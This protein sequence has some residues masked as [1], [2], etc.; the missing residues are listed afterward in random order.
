MNGQGTISFDEIRVDTNYV[1]KEGDKKADDVLK[2][3]EFDREQK[4][5]I[6]PTDDT[7]V[8]ES[9]IYLGQAEVLENESN[10]DRRDRLADLLYQNPGL[11]AQFHQRQLNS[12]TLETGLGD[13]SE[14]EDEDFY[15]PASELL[16]DC[17]QFLIRDSLRRAQERL[18]DERCRADSQDVHAIIVQRRNLN[19][20]LSKYELWGSQVV[21]SRPVSG[22][23]LSPDQKFVACGSWHG[24]AK[25][26]DSE[27]L[28]I[29]TS[30]DAIH[31]DKIGGLDW[32][33]DSTLLAT[34]G[35]DKLV[36]VWKP[37]SPKDS[38]VELKGH[39]GRVVKVKFHPSDRYVASASFDMTWRLWDVEK[40]IEL[41]LQ[42]GHAKEVYCLDFQCD[43]SLLCSAGLDS[44][45][46]IWDMR[47]G[48]SLM[49]LEGHAKPI[50]GVSW[51]PNGH[52]VAT[53]SADGTVKVWDI[54]KI[55]APFSILAHNNIVSDVKF[56]K[57]SGKTLVTSSYDKTI[58]VFA[59]D[60]WLKL[61]SLKGHTD[62][63]MSVDIS[64]DFSHLYSSG[65][66]RS[67]K[68]WK[69]GVCNS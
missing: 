24:D 15:T 3:L 33:S 16:V 14:S 59:S 30:F 41:Q 17:R 60:S 9:L 26:I 11:R 35:A 5:T 57:D 49:V 55:G 19:A 46:R 61:A 58:S 54:R 8:R 38:A 45:G 22:V 28:E 1:L 4:Q 42:E 18:R 21:S 48:Q 27:S 47:S 39:E 37:F 50:Y 62:K 53:G 69:L 65:W 67:V 25:I 68:V 64:R 34:G 12:P 51:S 31:D 32:S 63:V 44:I 52:H 66:D 13:A 10:R 56:D 20:K 2:N 43:G 36:K 6:V 7:E 23:A 29:L 40:Q